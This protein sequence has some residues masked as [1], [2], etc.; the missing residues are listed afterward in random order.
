[1]TL[2]ASTSTGNIPVTRN[3]RE[4]R[5]TKRTSP[6]LMQLLKDSLHAY[7][8]VTGKSYLLTA[9]LPASATQAAWIDF[10][11]IGVI[12]DQLNIMTYDF[13]GGWD[14]LSNHN[15]PLY[16][17]TGADSTRCVDAAFRL[18]TQ[19]YG[20]PA[21]K[22]NLGLP[23]YGRTYA[24]CTALNSR[25]AGVDSSQGVAYADIR[26]RMGDFTRKLGRPGEGAIPGE[27]RLE[28]AGVL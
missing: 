21:S 5:T 1:M 3:T 15:C 24:G 27:H 11:K 23:F 26:A 28:H 6:C 17:S 18:Y 7:G 9:A 13:H 10:D 22:I 25:H 8:A 16:P 14:P 12:L 20:V 2:T 4:L 19:I